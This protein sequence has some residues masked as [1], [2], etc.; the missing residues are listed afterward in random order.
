M[1][2]DDDAVVSATGTPAAAAPG[3]RTVA[4]R[5][6]PPTAAPPGSLA[7]AHVRARRTRPLTMLLLAILL[8]GSGTAILTAM[9]HTSATFDEIVMVAGGARG[10]ETGQWDIAPEHPPLTQYL[11]G[12]PV[13]VAGAEYPDESRVPERLRESMA[14]RYY[15]AQQF[16]WTAGNDPER[17]AF[18]GRLPAVA[19]ALA[20]VL[21]T[22]FFTRG[23][24]GDAPA[25]LA[26]AVVAFLP[27]VLAHGGVA[28]N[29]VPV[30]L[31]ILASL[32]LIDG[33]LR[34]PAPWRGALAGVAIGLALATKNSAIAIAPMAMLLFAL[35]ALVQR[36][37][38]WAAQAALSALAALAVG[39]VTL[40]LAYRGD[41][42]LEE[43]RYAIG[44]VTN[45]V[46]GR[47]TPAYLLGEVRP[48]GWW[49]YF[50]VAFVFKTSAGL[51][52]LLA[53]SIGWL[54]LSLRRAPLRAIA[55]P[56]RVPVV[57]LLV[58]GALLLTSKLN[59][60]FRYA[61]PALPLV[62]VLAA[63]GA[64]RAW[65]EATEARRTVRV[66]I[67]VAVALL[68]LHPL[69]YWPHFLTYVSEYGPG[70]DLNHRVL[71]DSSLDWGQGLLEL[72]D[73]MQA[74]GI[75]SVYLSYFGSALPAGY[76][77][78][79]VP[80]PSF[81]PLPPHPAGAPAEEPRWA[82]VSATNLV[83][84][85]VGPEVFAG[86]RAAPPDT[87]LGHTIFVYR[88]GR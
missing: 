29:D 65:R 86:L 77:I 4:G 63:V 42:L 52:L 78:R 57:G 72:R 16:Y 49:Y 59:I 11:Y 38:R 10:W 31:A 30:T 12:L 26:A 6:S 47:Q 58:F 87:V 1:S 17:V 19:A 70:R 24:F 41:V 85:Y 2:A 18:L 69:S 44:F 51:H 48:D 81:F 80:L 5:P 34:Q 39:Y 9:Q 60:G 50:P 66:A 43:W 23:A 67:A 27:D 21:A 62:A 22:F 20:L 53:V 32:W 33:A 75:P 28:Y 37:R 56:L 76:G 35:E 36:D 83:G 74:N 64:V 61:M 88:I 8:L 84:P 73:Y 46:G 45:Q 14:Y 82:A 54:A 55:S 68:V 15:Y 7:P 40:V 79:Y 3:G 71:A 25:L 13:W